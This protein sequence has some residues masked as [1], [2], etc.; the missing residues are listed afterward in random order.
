MSSFAVLFDFTPTTLGR[1]VS[2]PEK[3]VASFFENVY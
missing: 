3:I 1:G 2:D